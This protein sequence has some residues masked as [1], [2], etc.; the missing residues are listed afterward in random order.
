MQPT[1]PLRLTNQKDT[2]TMAH[3]VDSFVVPVPTKKVD[4]YRK[5]AN[6]FGKICIEH[7][8]LQYTEAV[9]DDVSV[10]K[11]TSFPQAIKMKD[12]ETVVVA[13]VT[14]KS[15]SHRDKVVAKV[16]ADSRLKDMGNKDKPF[17][18]KR[19]FWGGFKTIVTLNT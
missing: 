17:D 4:A 18:G 7:G 6:K 11:R 14:Y 15:R 13:W 16:M 2:D 10:G 9:A 8:A 1:L 5:M 12:D 3:Y 19:M